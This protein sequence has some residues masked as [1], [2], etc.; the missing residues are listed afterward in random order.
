MKLVFDIETDGIDAT[1]IWCI[2]AQDVDTKKIYRW[3]PD[4]IS[5]GLSFL[6]NAD[7]LIGHN[8]I[9][10]DLAVIANLYD[11]HFF[12][13]KLYDTWIMS[14][15]LK[16]K[17]PHKHG[18]G[19]WGEHLEYSKFDFDN[20]SEFSEEMLEYCVRDVELNC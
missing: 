5:S 3:R 8:I 2:V 20:W 4:D 7:A 16:Y 13:K 14:Q 9:G 18:L 10:Y 17:R 11:V 12:D 15:V 1:R 19:G 6:R